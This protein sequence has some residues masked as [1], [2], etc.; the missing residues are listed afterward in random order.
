MKQLLLRVPD[1]LHQR[2]ADRARHEGRSVNVIA[3]EM[4]DTSVAAESGSARHV[5]RAR[6]AARGL[7]ATVVT[8]TVEPPPIEVV[9]K[10]FRKVRLTAAELIDEQR[11]TR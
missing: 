8:P 9:V 2:L 5:V 7:L 3:T 11:G 10:A 1:E 4:L 6:A